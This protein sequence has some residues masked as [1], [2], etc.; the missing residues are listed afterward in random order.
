MLKFR[1]LTATWSV[2]IFQIHKNLIRFF[3]KYN[4]IYTLFTKPGS[5]KKNPC[6]FRSTWTISSIIQC[7]EH[8]SVIESKQLK[9]KYPLYKIF[10]LKI[11]EG[12]E[13]LKRGSFTKLFY[14]KN[15]F[16][17]NLIILK[18]NII[19]LRIARITKELILLYKAN[20]NLY[21]KI[22]HIYLFVH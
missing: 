21:I 1:S 8:A 6:R 3:Y 16:F 11:K 20:I 14:I 9:K 19:C 13:N 17:A 7:S 22:Q 10:Y 12:R 5:W 2:M 4:T 15:E 18:G